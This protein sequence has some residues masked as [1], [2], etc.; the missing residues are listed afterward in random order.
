MPVSLP[1]LLMWS[2]C[3]LYNVSESVSEYYKLEETDDIPFI[4][5]TA[6]EN[7]MLHCYNIPKRRVGGADCELTPADVTDLV[8]KE[9]PQHGCVNWNLYYNSCEASEHNPHNGAIN[10]DNIGYAWIAIFQVCMRVYELAKTLKS[11]E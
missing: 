11:I 9:P 7:G 3:R 2:V 1:N 6:R 4:C 5:S 8:Y 10:F